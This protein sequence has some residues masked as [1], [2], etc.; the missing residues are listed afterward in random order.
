MGVGYTIRTLFLKM[1]QRVWWRNG[2]IFTAR[3]KQHK[4]FLWKRGVLNLGKKNVK[5]LIPFLYRGV[6]L[7]EGFYVVLTIRS[8]ESL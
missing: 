4:T 1:P 2:E 7:F 5:Q 8:L 6:S 3:G